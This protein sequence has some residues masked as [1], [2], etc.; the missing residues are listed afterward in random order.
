MP[1]ATV[2]VEVLGGDVLSIVQCIVLDADVFPYP[3]ADFTTRSSRYRTWIARGPDHARVVGFL[4]SCTMEGVMHVQGLAVDA[5]TRQRGIG[6]ALLR[7]CLESHVAT[8]AAAVALSV[9]VENRAAI[10][11]YESEGFVVTRRSCD[12]Y[13]A[14]VY[15]TQRDAFTMRRD[16]RAIRA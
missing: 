11:L 9:S 12:H 6:R 5:D 15:G 4:A 7:T 14:G 8:R 16:S 3:C 1:P 10:G 13:P 2:T